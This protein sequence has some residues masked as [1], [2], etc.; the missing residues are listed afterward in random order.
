MALKA[1]LTKAEFDALPEA[2]RAHYAEADG[3]FVL[4]TD[5]DSHPKVGGLRSALDKER[6]DRKKADKAFNDLKTKI[7]DMDPDQA[8]DALK[9]IQD[10][11]DKKLIDEGQIEQLLTVRTERMTTD[12]NN[13]IKTFQ[14]QLG[15]KDKKISSLSG[16]LKKLKINSAIERLALEKGVRKTAIDDAIARFTVI[17]IDGVLW[18]LD[19]NG[20]VIAK[21]GDQIAYGKDATK[22]MSFEEGFETL[23]TKAS[24]LF[25]TSAGGG[26]GNNGNGNR[27]TGPHTISREDARDP[28]KYR[29]A[30]KAAADAKVELVVAPPTAG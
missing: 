2:I 18:D 21:K 4:D 6:D 29:A 9:K 27:G 30:Q 23:A 10:L 12:H 11:A 24:H 20:G 28:M 16:E 17:G 25:E 13:Q 19:E 8:R 14:T 5:V 3:K 26:A 1:V 22:A 7:G 15:D